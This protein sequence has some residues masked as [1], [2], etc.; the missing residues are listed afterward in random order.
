MGLLMQRWSKGVGGVEKSILD[1]KE[2]TED[3]ILAQW[4][5]IRRRIVGL[6]WVV[7]YLK[8]L[9]S[10]SGGKREAGENG[11]STEAGSFEAGVMILTR[12]AGS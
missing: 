4:R 12:S 1:H 9:T 11:L 10:N 7:R 6:E 3:A 5:Q 8:I 2:E